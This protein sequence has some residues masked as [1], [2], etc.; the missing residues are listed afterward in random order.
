MRTECDHRARLY[1]QRRRL[2][3]AACE[4]ERAGGFELRVDAAVFLHGIDQVGISREAAHA[5]SEQRVFA[6]GFS[7]GKQHARRRARRF[8]RQ[9][10][11]LEQ[12]YREPCVREVVGD[13][14][15]THATP[16]HDDV[17]RH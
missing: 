6:L 5:P 3:I 15:T 4:V 8:A 2:G 14:D 1:T 13:G 17:V 12:A 16:Y 11:S 9:C 7:D 10:A